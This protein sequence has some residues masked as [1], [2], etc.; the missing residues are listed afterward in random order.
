MANLI[1]T[2]KEERAKFNGVV[3]EAKKHKTKMLNP[4]FANKVVCSVGV[5]AYID[6][7]ITR[8]EK[9]ELQ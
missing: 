4:N 5:V 8:L 6:T 9:G 7:L 3:E 2:L 1:Q